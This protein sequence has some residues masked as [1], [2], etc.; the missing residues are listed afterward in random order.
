M[1]T[2]HRYSI[3]E[4]VRLCET[5]GCRRD[6]TAKPV[7]RDQILRRERTGQGKFRSFSMITLVDAQSAEPTVVLSAQ[8]N[9]S[10]YVWDGTRP[11]SVGGTLPKFAIYSCMQV[12][13]RPDGCW[14]L[15]PVWLLPN[16]RV[17]QRTVALE[18]VKSSVASRA[19]RS[20]LCGEG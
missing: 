11:P 9:M 3:A 16:T 19:M 4:S 13:R 17:C 6:G 2:V 15:H 20:Y 18:A 7:S 10:L 5:G 8:A 12:S 1:L 14:W